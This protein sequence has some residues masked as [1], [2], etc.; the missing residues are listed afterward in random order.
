[1]LAF[2]TETCASKLRSH[3]LMQL[4]ALADFVG[5]ARKAIGLAVY[6]YQIAACIPCEGYSRTNWVKYFIISLV[7]LTFFYIIIVLLKVNLNSSYLSGPITAVQIICSP[8]TWALF[9]AWSL[10]N[11]ID[12]NTFVIKI[13]SALYGTLNLD[14]FRD[15]YPPFCLSPHY[16]AMTIIA[17][18]YIAALYPF[19]LIIITYFLIKLYD[20]NCL[21]VVWLWKP[22]KFLLNKFY[23]HYNSR[24]SL[25]ETIA[26]FILLSSVKISSVSIFLLTPTNTYDEFGN[27]NSIR[28]LYL[29][30]TIEWFGKEHLPYG[31]LAILT[32]FTFVIFPILLLL[33]YPCRCFQRLLNYFG[34]N[35]HT[36]R[37]F[38]DAF[39]G[40]YRLE[41]YDMRYL[42]AYFLFLR[43][44][45]LIVALSIGSICSF[46]AT[47]FFAVLNSTLTSVLHPYRDSSHNRIN[48]LAM[49]ML[50]LYYVSTLTML[51]TFYLD[52]H[53]IVIPN[54]F[55]AIV[56]VILLSFMIYVGVRT[57]V[58]F[59]QNGLCWKMKHKILSCVKKWR[60]NLEDSSN[61]QLQSFSERSL[62]T[63]HLRKK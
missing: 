32:G 53:W 14:F 3:L 28:Y 45:L 12:N 54:T 24:T 36:L 6:S 23:K 59:K 18:D 2:L 52:V 17:L 61:D 20:S 40:S 60:N 25:V 56:Q 33:L 34:L 26:N 37:V 42:S 15:V 19:L 21:L 62:L 38:I 55:F 9:K 48:S 47:A 22:F 63:P 11:T 31:V 16:N 27:L 5:S 39:Q 57:F 13:I 7:P 10:S 44:F 46:C 8:L 51:T 4:I 41:P 29:D 1:M 58:V 30:A 49:S 43:I 35:F 50:M